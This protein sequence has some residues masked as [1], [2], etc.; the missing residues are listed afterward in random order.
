[1]GISPQIMI[2]HISLKQ[3]PQQ[4]VSKLSIN[5]Q[6]QE[7]VRL[8][9][10]IHGSHHASERTVMS[11]KFRG[12]YSCHDGLGAGLH[13][14]LLGNGEV[15][16]DLPCSTLFLSLPPPFGKAGARAV[17]H[18]CSLFHM[19]VPHFGTMLTF[20]RKITFIL[21]NGSAMIRALRNDYPCCSS[22]VNSLFFLGDHVALFRSPPVPAGSSRTGMNNWAANSGRCDVKTSAGCGAWVPFS[23]KTHVLPSANRSIWRI[24]ETLSI[25]GECQLKKRCVNK[26]LCDARVH[27]IAHILMSVGS[28]PGYQGMVRKNSI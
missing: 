3:P 21:K 20:A 17:L 7:W 9:L 25:L 18:P 24:T 23:F 26:C 27:D 19:W 15:S 28:V 8:G 1:M 6:L 11:L 10:I 12:A 14:V 22:S 5:V 16:R 13:R 4:S 2:D